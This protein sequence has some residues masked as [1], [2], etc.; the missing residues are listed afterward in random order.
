M[1]MEYS[2]KKLNHYTQAL[3]HYEQIGGYEENLL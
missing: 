3:E 1:A 2:D